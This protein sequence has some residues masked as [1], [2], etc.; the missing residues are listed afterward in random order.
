MMS[1]KKKTYNHPIRYQTYMQPKGSDGPPPDSFGVDPEGWAGPYRVADGW[2]G[3]WRI[4]RLTPPEGPILW[5]RTLR[6]PKPDE[7]KK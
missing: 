2:E 5:K 4:H 6:I 7:E 3:A 1:E